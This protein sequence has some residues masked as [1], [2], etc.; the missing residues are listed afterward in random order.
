M[1]GPLLP[2]SYARAVVAATIALVASASA[3]PSALRERQMRSTRSL[4]ILQ[5]A[6][7]ND[8]VMRR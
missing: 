4:P 6:V 1:I 3:E 2:Q 7:C 5:P 8:T